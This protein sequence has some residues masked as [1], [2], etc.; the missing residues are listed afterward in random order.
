M[1]AIYPWAEMNVGDVREVST[2]RSLHAVRSAGY[3]WSKK[4]RRGDGL[5]PN[6][7]VKWEDST[8]DPLTDAPLEV[9]RIERTA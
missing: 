4:H 3:E 5:R 7:D 2:P 8:H 1:K 9:Y 6:F